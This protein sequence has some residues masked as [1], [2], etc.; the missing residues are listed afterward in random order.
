MLIL[1]SSFSKKAILKTIFLAFALI[2]SCL[3]NSRGVYAAVFRPQITIINSSA[4]APEPSPES[5]SEIEWIENQTYELESSE[6]A[7]VKIDYDL[8]L[9]SH[10]TV[11]G[12][13]LTRLKDYFLNEGST[14]I[15][16]D[17]SYMSSLPVGTYS[18]IAYYSDD[19]SFSTSFSIVEEKADNT[20]ALAPETGKNGNAQSRNEESSI[21]GIISI[22]LLVLSFSVF[23]ILRRQK[24]YKLKRSFSF[25]RLNISSLYPKTSF[26]F[27]TTNSF[28][29]H[30]NKII[31]ISIAS[32]FMLSGLCYVVN[33]LSILSAKNNTNALDNAN[34]SLSVSTS[35]E[36]YAQEVDLSTGNAFV[37][38]TQD[39]IVNSSTRNGYQLYISSSS[40]KYNE[41]SINGS[42]S[43]DKIIS[44]TSGTFVSPSGLDE[45]SWGY[46]LSNDVFG[47]IQ[48]LSQNSNWAGVPVYGAEAL[49]KNIYGPTNSGDS[50]T[51]YYGF[52][53][54]DELPNGNYFGTENSVVVYTAVANPVVE[55]TTTYSCN[56]GSGVIQ[57]QVR[58]A[59]TTIIL[60]SG[61][62]CSLSGNSLKSWNT[63]PDGSGIEYAPGS[64]YSEDA[65]LD[66]YAIWEAD[67]PAEEYHT[68]ILRYNANGGSGAPATQTYSTTAD[69][70]S[71][72][73]SSSIP[74]RSGYDFM[75]W[76][77][78]S[79]ASTATYKGGNYISITSNTT[80]F[81]IWRKKEPVKV[82]NITISGS[83]NINLNSTNHKATLSAT[84][85][86]AD[87]ANK[88]V[89]WSSNNT[90]VATVD[91]SGTVTGVEAGVAVI[92]A[93]ANDGSGIKATYNISVK[94][95]II[96]ILG[97]SQIKRIA[98]NDY[99][100]ISSYTDTSSKNNYS[101]GA[102]T[103]RFFYK[104]GR[105]FQYETGTNYTE[106]DDDGWS[107]TTDFIKKYSS[108]KSYVEFYVYFTISMN[109]FKWY[110]CGQIE[111][112]VSKSNDKI[113]IPKIQ[114]QVEIYN[115]KILSLRNSGYN[116]NGYLTS[117]HPMK[118]KQATSKYMVY[119]SN[120]NACSAKYRS[121][122][123][124]NTVNKKIKNVIKSG[125][126]AGISFVNTFDD[127]VDTSNSNP[128]KWSYKTDWSSYSTSD[129]IHWD[130][131]T[132][133]KYF[134][135][136]MNKNSAL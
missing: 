119:N 8:S 123:K 102:D 13:E 66:L 61:D 71:F 121:N 81:A 56:G 135:H 23:K 29:I 67:S 107:K 106:G 79:A 55:Y 96:I 92:T 62:A 20:S 103:L 22:V 48:D 57:N 4:P 58:E 51:F 24:I 90:K 87:A 25:H 27:H 26:G 88:S 18:L 45:N 85:T 113:N 41:L 53:I 37:Y 129:G 105:G 28:K 84:V 44:A 14:I 97:A 112:G 19:K 76:N 9:F 108:K 117:A 115:N 33:N 1:R 64:S 118:P 95:K 43:T 54:N 114:K 101:V 124:Y 86:P 131:N 40:N 68:Y 83:N 2:S 46:A 127:I 134:N 94:K 21:I 77:T 6:D 31:P 99:A 89:T 32:V 60:D 50:T 70:A 125:N 93:S 38:T 35:I 73:I 10:L 30:H 82:S 128:A 15:T 126:Y 42:S 52:Y 5:T 100:N 34:N 116:I 72:L 11:N 12:K 3:I 109:D 39:V 69:S 130:N 80:L 47:N 91:S 120:S 78:N 16:L 136:W 122:L 65:N 63:K 75:G 59:G 132:A 111:S 36:D 7:V 74:N 110:T 49:A 98:G 17:S 104:S 133:K